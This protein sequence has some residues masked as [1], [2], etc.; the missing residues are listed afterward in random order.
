MDTSR[1]NQDIS[2]LT[3][4][5]C[6]REFV[7]WSWFLSFIDICVMLHTFRLA[8]RMY[9]IVTK[10]TFVSMKWC[11]EL[12]TMILIWTFSYRFNEW[13]VVVLFH[14]PLILSDTIETPHSIRIMIDC[15]NIWR[16][17]L[18]HLFQN[19]GFDGIVK[20]LM[21]GVP[22]PVLSYQQTLKS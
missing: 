18:L 13:V 21:N 9:L 10:S 22:T 5:L 2:W 14:F 11:E 1:G 4:V 19:R 3:Q 12:N 6:G 17:D 8:L 15:R 16:S 20:V 7:E